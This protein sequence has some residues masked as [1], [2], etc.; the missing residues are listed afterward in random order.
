MFYTS[1]AGTVIMGPIIGGTFGPFAAGLPSNSA[2]SN[3]YQSANG[4]ANGSST[5]LYISKNRY[6][7]NNGSSRT[8]ATNDFF[9]ND[10]ALRVYAS[11]PSVGIALGNTCAAV[12]CAWYVRFTGL[13]QNN[14]L[15]HRRHLE[16]FISMY[17]HDLLYSDQGS[18]QT[19]K[20][21][22]SG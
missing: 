7:V 5:K 3:M 1:A 19:F 9:S 14:V 16:D 22:G 13:K 6:L 20:Y 8:Q 17:P 10:R 11:V 18:G 21:L 4:S 2:I 15:A 12:E